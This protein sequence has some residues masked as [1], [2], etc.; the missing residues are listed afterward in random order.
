MPHPW[1]IDFYGECHVIYWYAQEGR[2]VLM[3]KRKDNELEMT[4]DEYRVSSPDYGELIIEMV[5]NISNKDYLRKIYSFTKVIYNKER[6]KKE[7]S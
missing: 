3:S 7:D 1:I 2:M 6:N 4:N 5:H